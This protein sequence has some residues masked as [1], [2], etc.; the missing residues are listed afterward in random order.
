MKGGWVESSYRAYA[1]RMRTAA[2]A[3]VDDLGLVQ[4]VC[5]S[6]EFDHAG[7]A[8]EGQAFFIMMQVA[9]GALSET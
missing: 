6:P 1:D 5:G 3:K 4:G 8:T 7:T 9:H 2:E